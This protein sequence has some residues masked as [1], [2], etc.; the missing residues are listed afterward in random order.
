MSHTPAQPERPRLIRILLVAVAIA[1]AGCVNGHDRF[2]SE[3]RFVPR[4]REEAEAVRRMREAIG[5][6]AMLLQ[7]P[8]LSVEDKDRLSQAI[9]AS[10]WALDHYEELRSRGDTRV[11]VM[12]GI[13]KASAAIVADDVTGVGTANDFLL[14]PLALGAMATYILTEGQASSEELAQ[15]WLTVG[16][17][18]QELSTTLDEIIHLTSRG[19]VAD[20]GIMEE[21]YD[22]LGR[23]GIPKT[24]DNV[25]RALA[26][27]ME[28]AEQANDETK[29]LRIRKTQKAKRC[30]WSRHSRE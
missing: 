2:P 13:G 4:N 19:N 3:Q 21:V 17:R 28:A 24:N 11:Y 15:A 8:E 7:D 9:N 18:I 30:R 10:R 14:I 6:A 1:T 22:L 23:M 16:Y 20:T 25:C 26:I 27:L 5:L 12:A 29:K